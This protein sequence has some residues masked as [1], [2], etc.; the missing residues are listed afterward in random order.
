MFCML[1]RKHLTG[2]ADP[3]AEPAATG[4]DSGISGW[5][6][7]TSWATGWSAAW[8]WRPWAAG[9]TSCCWTGRGVSST[10]SAGWTATLSTSGQLL[11]GL[12]YCQPPAPD[13]LN[14]LR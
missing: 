13:K 14:P 6:P 3:G 10:A 12:F 2:G 11:P 4:A 9:P 1:L 5:R 8:C 7:W